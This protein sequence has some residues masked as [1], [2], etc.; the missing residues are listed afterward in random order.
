MYSKVEIH[1]SVVLAT[2][3]FQLSPSTQWLILNVPHESQTQSV[4][5]ETHLFSKILFSTVL[6]HPSR[7]QIIN[8]NITIVFFLSSYFTHNHSAP[9]ILLSKL[10]RQVYPF[11]FLPTAS[12]SVYVYIYLL[13]QNHDQFSLLF[14]TLYFI[15]SNALTRL[16]SRA[17]EIANLITPLPSLKCFLSSQVLSEWNSNTYTDF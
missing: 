15:S 9:A 6:N 7:F 2:L 5:N 11:L 1:W 16:L 10:N 8:P 3:N 14:I 17:L 4:Q 13:S 12:S